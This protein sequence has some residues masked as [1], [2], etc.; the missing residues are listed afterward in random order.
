MPDRALV[1]TAGIGERLRPLSLTRAKPAVPLAGS[2]L[3]RRILTWL[4]GQGIDRVVLNLHHRPS[5]ITG[6]LGDGQDLGVAVRYS[7][8]PVLLGS[9][10]GIRHALDLVDAERFFIVNGDTLTDADLRE[11]NAH[12][13][14]AG[15][16]VTL[17]LVKHPAPQRYGG[18]RLNEGWISDF[19]APG[20]D[21]DAC[22]F[23]GAQVVEASAF[24]GLADGQPAASIGGLYRRLLSGPKRTLAGFRCHARF[25]DV[26]TPGDY[27]R[28]VRELAPD[29]DGR[30]LIGVGSRVDPTAQLVRTVLWDD[31]QVGPRA[32]LRDCVVA[33]GARIPADT[34]LTA[35]AIAPACGERPRTGERLLG[36]L[37]VAP[38]EGGVSTQHTPPEG[39]DP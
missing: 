39:A 4:K 1:L 24:A 6:R 11:L 19:T 8:E 12:H 27:L 18:V 34:T 20:A 33:D 26:G 13:E 31:V 14:R 35:Q 5:T 2:S 37:L 29:L 9:A 32:V 15:A 30:Q 36:E 7:W 10:G 38:L 3:I 21:P 16:S 22:H 28:T 17:A 23:V 25:L